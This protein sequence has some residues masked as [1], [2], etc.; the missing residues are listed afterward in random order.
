[1]SVYTAGGQALHLGDQAG[2]GGEATVFRVQGQPDQLAKLY[3]R[4]ARPGY[5][6]KLA[7]MLDN[8][9][10]NPTRELRHASLAWPSGLLYDSPRTGSARLVGYLMPFVRGSTPIL[11][12]Y[13]PRLR[14]HTLPDFNARYLHRAARNLSAALSAVHSRGYVVGDLN[15]SNILVTPEA[16][17]TIIDTD[18]FQVQAGQN[19]SMQTYYCPVGKAEYTPP[20]LQGKPLA[21]VLRSPEQDAF[22]L[23][24]LIFQ[25]LMDGNHPFRAHWLGRGDPPPLEAKI[26]Q[27][28]FPYVYAPDLPVR[29]PAQAPGLNRLHPRLGELVRRCFADG[30]SRPALRPSPA[31]WEMA[32]AE[33]ESCLVECP[34]RHV[35]SSHL[36]SCPVCAQGGKPA[37]QAGAAR[38]V[39]RS[40]PT[41]PEPPPPAGGKPGPGAA[42][43]AGPAPTAG[44]GA[45][46]AASS[47]ARP[48]GSSRTTWSARRAGRP[49]SP[50][51][52]SSRGRGAPN[53]PPA[54]Q[55]SGTGGQSN[56]FPRLQKV[57]VDFARRQATA[58][59]RSRLG[60]PPASPPPSAGQPSANPAGSATGRGSRS[61]WNMPPNPAP[62]TTG[63]RPPGRAPGSPWGSASGSASGSPTGSARGNTPGSASSI[64]WGNIPWRS[65]PHPVRYY[66]TAFRAVP[67]KQTLARGSGY[68]AL[69]GMA[70]GLPLA[71]LS[72]WLEFELAFAMLV[73]LS[74]AAAGGSR[75]WKPGENLNE[76][77]THSIG[78][79]N[80]LR[81]MGI[82]FGALLG[83]LVTLPF[84]LVIFPLFIGLI[85]GA[86]LGN[87][88]GRKAWQ[89]GLI[90]GWDRISPVLATGGA[91]LSTSLLLGW[92]AHSGAGVQAGEWA[93]TLSAWITAQSGSLALGEAGAGMAAG[94]AGGAIAGLLVD[95]SARVAG[96]SD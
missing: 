2:A 89:K 92:L 37:G 39:R 53:P 91:A 52:A 80:L 22:A 63:A 76:V 8:P 40:R 4:P 65:I 77:V 3:D 87:I 11:N 93:A 68:G 88:A 44:A 18:S 62:S 74:A 16:L 7:W 84:F 27:G 47:Q 90:V 95:V 60:M 34:R 13:N 5:A 96:L 82:A 30:H 28:Y 45:A 54:G 33:A 61:A 20:E 46:A 12:I 69:A 21:R 56:L 58:Y 55:S 72:H 94:L 67:W 15:E 38:G 71:L 50:P 49:G 59:I 6:E 85:G 73:A 31:D 17:V 51:N 83:L 35:Y 86:L 19:G 66:R 10:E 24:V 81:W 75:G 23:G 29:P 9:P 36:V 79:R 1:M 43:G 26:A 64:P 42:A 32:I 14:R 25:L 41:V 70:V 57:A 48:A 78:W